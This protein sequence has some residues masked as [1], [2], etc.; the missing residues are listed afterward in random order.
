MYGSR[1]RVLRHPSPWLTCQRSLCSRVAPA[2][3]LLLHSDQCSLHRPVPLDSHPESTTR[4]TAVLGALRAAYENT[5]GVE[6]KSNPRVAT[7]EDL[8]RVH[9]RE[10]IDRLRAAFDAVERFE[11]LGPPSASAPT[12]GTGTMPDA[13]TWDNTTD[14]DRRPSFF[15]D[16]DTPASIGSRSAVL[17]AAGAAVEAVDAIMAGSATNAFCITRPPGHHAEADRAMG[18][19]FVNHAAVAAAHALENRA[20]AVSYVLLCPLLLSKLLLG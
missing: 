19:C 16:T 10:H 15:F 1:L 20:S 7:E 18:F 3:T 13:I 4:A 5:D 6:W 8:L 14:V 11:G 12:F 2:P 17:A 9:T